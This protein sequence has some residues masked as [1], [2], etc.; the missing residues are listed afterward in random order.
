M[1]HVLL[2]AHFFLIYNFLGVKFLQMAL[3]TTP[4]IISYLLQPHTLIHTIRKRFRKTNVQLSNMQED[5]I[6]SR[7]DLDRV[8]LLT[9]FQL[10]YNTFL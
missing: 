1:V 6:K 8:R 9:V 7:M 4:L 2:C 3:T 5:Y 10:I